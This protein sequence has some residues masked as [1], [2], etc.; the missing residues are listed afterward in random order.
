[1]QT[2]K[3]IAPMI[4]TLTAA[5]AAGGVVQMTETDNGRTNLVNTG[6]EIEITLEGN[7]TTGYSWDMASFSTNSLQQIG[8]VQYRQTEQPDKRPRVGVGGQFMFK[9]KAV[10]QGQS[11]IK[12]I[13]R[14]S[15][16]TTA[17]DKV[18]S[19]VLEIR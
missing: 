4:V 5:C 18:Y 15:W 14:R 2:I 16:E 6:S 3:F 13:Y 19:V 8:T 10:K 1:M 11:D 7:P 17:C 9:F 12:L